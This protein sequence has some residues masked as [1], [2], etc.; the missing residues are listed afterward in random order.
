MWKIAK[1]AFRWLHPQERFMLQGLPGTLLGTRKD[2]PHTVNASGTARPPYLVG[3]APG[4]VRTEL[5][6]S[7]C[8]LPTKL[9]PEAAA[10]VTDTA[11]D[12]Q[13]VANN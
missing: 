6:A 3:A 5:P 1:V 10:K 4:P 12:G 8:D 7:L 13:K 9:T 2:T 11:V